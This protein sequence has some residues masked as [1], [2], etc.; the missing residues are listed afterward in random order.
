[1]KRIAK[2]GWRTYKIEAML[3]FLGIVLMVALIYYTDP[4][5]LSPSDTIQTMTLVVLIMVTVSYARSTQK[6]YEVAQ[7]AELNAVFPIISMTPEVLSPSQI[8]ISYENIG[9][10]PALNLRIWLELK[11]HAQFSYLKSEAKK[12]EGFRAAVGVNQSCQRQWDK[13]EG[14]LPTTSSGFDIVA[15][16]TDVFQQ[17][18][19]S[20]LTIINHYDHEF[21]FGKKVKHQ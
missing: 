3:S 16:Y 21:S 4:D 15:E 8:R 6:L 7:N 10:G 11:G 19:E 17:K 9:R 5:W 14:P 13:T 18:F 1:M 2:S 12:N 20:R